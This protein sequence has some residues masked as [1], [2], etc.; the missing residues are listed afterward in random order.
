MYVYL[1]ERHRARITL[2]KRIVQQYEAEKALVQEFKP[3]EFKKVFGHIKIVSTRTSNIV[4]YEI[5][6]AKKL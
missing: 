2:K 6:K 5:S 3:L 4:D 1:L